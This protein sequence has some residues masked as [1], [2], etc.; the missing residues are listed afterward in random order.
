MTGALTEALPVLRILVGTP[1]TSII[2]LQKNR[3]CFAILVPGRT[4]VAVELW[5]LSDCCCC[6]SCTCSVSGTLFL[7][8][9]TSCNSFMYVLQNCDNTKW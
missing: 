6:L 2:L 8:F 3:E 7:G 5:P 1:V 4:E 9:Q